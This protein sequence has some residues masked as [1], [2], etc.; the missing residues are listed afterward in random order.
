EGQFDDVS[1][2]DRPGVAA[3]PDL[4]FGTRTERTPVVGLIYVGPQPE[5]ASQ[6]EPIAREVVSTVLGTR[7]VAVVDIDTRMP[8]DENLL[9]TPAQLESA[10]SRM[11]VVIT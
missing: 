3:R 6:R 7:D 5:Y 1:A 2:R 9:R 4:S 10:I 8:L 11:D